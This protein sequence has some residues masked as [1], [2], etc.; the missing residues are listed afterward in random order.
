MKKVLTVSAIFLT[1]AFLST[2]AFAGKRVIHFITLPL[3]EGTG[4]AADVLN[5]INAEETHTKAAS[6]VN[7]SLLATQA[8][9]GILM[10]TNFDQKVPTVRKIHRFIAYTVLASGIWL[11]ISTSI[12]NGTKRSAS[13]YLSIAHPLCATVP[14]IMFSF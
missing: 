6:V 8:T 12:D 5:L 10:A 1:V 7:L 14:I 9:F 13:Q 4:I 2:S 3:I 11:A